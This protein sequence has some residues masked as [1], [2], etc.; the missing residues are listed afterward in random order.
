[1]K[2]L[3]MF[4][5]SIKLRTWA[6]FP[7][8]IITLLLGLFVHSSYAYESSGVLPAGTSNAPSYKD[9]LFS[10]PNS[11]VV[12]V[13]FGSPVAIVETYKDSCG[14][15]QALTGCAFIAVRGLLNIV[16]SL[17]CDIEGTPNQ[18]MCLRVYNDN[19]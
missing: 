4:L 1:M 9:F 5:L 19:K 7:R 16:G 12:S 15:E 10:I 2:N 17:D 13:N 8:I 6:V 14:G 11:G 3:F 18:K